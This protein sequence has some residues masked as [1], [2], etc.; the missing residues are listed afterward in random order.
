GARPAW[1]ARGGGGGPPD[2]LVA[3]GAVLL[4]PRLSSQ[5]LGDAIS[6]QTLTVAA[7]HAGAFLLFAHAAGLYDRNVLTRRS[8]LAARVAVTAILSATATLALLYLVLYRPL[9]RWVTAYTIALATPGAFLPRALVQRL[10]QVRG[11]RLLFVGRD[12]LSERML[13]ALARR[14]ELPYKV[15]GVWSDG[16]FAGPE[17]AGAAPVPADRLPDLVRSQD[18][19]DVVLPTRAPDSEA[20]LGPAPGCLPLGCRVRIAADLYEEIYRSVPVA[21]VPPAWLLSRGWDTSDR[22][23]EGLKRGSDVVLA[24]VLLV[25]A[26]PV[27]LLA[28]LLIALAGDG[29]VFYSQL[30]VGRY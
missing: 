19:D 11:R 22:L 27:G 13:L 1:G 15:V 18:V 6:P 21:D 23:A 26:T 4:G 5:F 14:E 7:L 10:L 12:P 28:A 16:A 9:G 24:L 2:G 25:V 29:P 3:G 20:A 30:R 8:A 17:G